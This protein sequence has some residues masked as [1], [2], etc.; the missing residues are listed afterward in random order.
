MN[1]TPLSGRKILIVEDD[2]SGRLYLNK[3]LEH[4]G[5]VLLNAVTGLEAVNIVRENP[6]IDLVLMDIQIPVMD[7]YKATH[8][9]RKYRP[10]LIIIAQTAYDKA[11]EN[12]KFS[13]S[14][15]TDYI[16]KPIL[17]EELI[18]KLVLYLT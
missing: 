10:D 11:G 14:G 16:I 6:D 7:G 8:E 4:R 12:S 17:I 13:E 9:I 3:I 1:A 2:F 5:A 15:F 18:R